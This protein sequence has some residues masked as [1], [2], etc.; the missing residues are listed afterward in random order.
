M[1]WKA[2]VYGDFTQEN[3][4]MRIANG[5]DYLDFTDK[6]FGVDDEGRIR[7]GETVSGGRDGKGRTITIT[8]IGDLDI[9]SVVLGH[10]A[11]RDG[12]VG[13]DNKQET[14]DAVIAHTKMAA[15][16]RAEGANFNGSAVG[17]DLAVYDYA[18]SVG[19]MSIMAKYAD[20]MYDSSGD[21]W[22]L[23]K[24]GILINDGHARVV[25][26]NGKEIISLE[27]LGMS[28]DQERDTIGALAR[29]FRISEEEAAEINKAN[30]GS[31]Q[32]GRGAGIGGDDYANA[33]KYALNG[34]VNE[35]SAEIF[36]G[37]FNGMTTNERAEYLKYEVI[38]GGAFIGD[39]KGAVAAKL[40]EITGLHDENILNEL[41]YTNI[42]TP[43]DNIPIPYGY[44]DTYDFMNEP[45]RE[46]LNLNSRGSSEYTMADIA[47]KGFSVMSF[48][49]SLYHLDTAYSD[50]KKYVNKDGREVIWGF[51]KQTNKY[52][53]INS[54]LYRST[55]NYSDAEARNLIREGPHYKFD[56]RPFDYEY[57]TG[58][59]PAIGSG[60]RYGVV[61]TMYNIGKTLSNGL[62]NML[63]QWNVPK[64]SGELMRN[65]YMDMYDMGWGY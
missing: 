27:D 24:N 21:Y 9:M 45:L 46:F 62:S 15:R 23:T 55:F 40:R 14:R 5:K 60:I 22:E 34:T 42:L 8:D 51:N 52:E 28:K 38:I 64:S 17:L 47:G 13:A 12:S 3:T 57:G 65:M 33:L 35:T 54:E 18:R 20:A 29:M 37:I 1:A 36:N 49:G 30:N 25:D 10:E 56:M 11:Y 19:N 2:Y 61:D 4:A 32:L 53:Q 16:M 26:E 59:F 7:F 6:D 31:I 58:L 39:D 43:T 48:I 41:F 44:A 50:I 63:R